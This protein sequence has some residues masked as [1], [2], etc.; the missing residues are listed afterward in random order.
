MTDHDRGQVLD[1]VADLG[2]GGRRGGGPARAAPLRGRRLVRGPLGQGLLTGRYR[3]GRRTG[4]HRAGY[5]PQH[6]SDER[7]QQL[8]PL[9][10][11]AGLRMT[12]LAMAFAI[13]HPAVTA[14]NLGPRTMEQ[15]DDLLAGAEVTLEPPT[16]P[17]GVVG[18]PSATG[19]RTA[20]PS[21]RPRTSDTPDR[22]RTTGHASAPTW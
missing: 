16:T 18:E 2:F 13:A 9:A 4:T 12:H 14:A 8:V 1:Q 11:K 17:G 10:G 6:V 21:G 20:T 19:T 5:T 7:K 3:M 15:L 22:C